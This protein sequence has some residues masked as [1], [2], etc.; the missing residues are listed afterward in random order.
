MFGFRFFLFFIFSFLWF[1][2]EKTVICAPPAWEP[3]CDSEIYCNNAL[4]CVVQTSGIYNDSKTFVDQP[5][6]T[7]PE[8][9]LKFAFSFYLFLFLFLS[10]FSHFFFLFY[11]SFF[12]LF[13]ISAFNALGPTPTTAQ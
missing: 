3:A 2:G 7:S 12:R 4:L 13:F 1:S 5:L 11:S 6:K 10:F 9:V 8:I